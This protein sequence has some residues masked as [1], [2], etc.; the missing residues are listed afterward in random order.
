MPWLRSALSRMFHQRREEHRS[1]H[2]QDSSV[3]QQKMADDLLLVAIDTRH[4]DSH[5]KTALQERLFC[6]QRDKRSQPLLA[7]DWQL[8]R[9]PGL[10]EAGESVCW[11]SFCLSWKPRGTHLTFALRKVPCLSVLMVS[12]HRPVTQ[13]FDLTFLMSMRSKTSLST[14]D[15]YSRRFA[16]ASCL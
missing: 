8:I 13:F 1:C 11:Q 3:L 6:D 12:T 10:V 15:L 4:H 7:A 16:S 5:H 14:Q 2:L 9:Y